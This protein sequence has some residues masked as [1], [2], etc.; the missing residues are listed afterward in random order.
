MNNLEFKKYKVIFFG[1][2]ILARATPEINSHNS[3]VKLKLKKFIRILLIIV[4]IK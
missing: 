2:L 3:R 1:N 4:A